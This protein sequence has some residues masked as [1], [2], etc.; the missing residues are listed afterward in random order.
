MRQMPISSEFSRR[1]LLILLLLVGFVQ[2]IQTACA[3]DDQD[4]DLRLS[5]KENKLVK[6]L[7]RKLSTRLSSKDNPAD[8]DTW[9]VLLLLDRAIARA[10]SPG[11]RT[12]WLAE[13]PEAIVVQG[14]RPAALTLMRHLMGSNDAATGLTNIASLATNPTARGAAEKQWRF[15]AFKTSDEAQVFALTLL[16]LKQ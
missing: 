14:K 13:K 5:P 9:Y 3:D 16:P 11:V 12:T 15:Q 1:F 2:G 7:E 8:R 10:D 4:L 6:G